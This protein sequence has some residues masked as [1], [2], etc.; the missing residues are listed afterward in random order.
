MA[1]KT[2]Q[3]RIDVTKLK[4][5]WFFK[6]EKGTYADLTVFYNEVPDQYQTNGMVVQQVP[7]DV[8]EKEKNLPKDQRTVGPILGN[9][10][11]W[12][13]QQNIARAEATPGYAPSAAQPTPQSAAPSTP[14][15]ADDLPF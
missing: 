9:A 11:D 13:T 6:G 4:K 15:T 2:I 5:E 8:Y 14:Q 10:K 1:D 3:L 7:K 12:A